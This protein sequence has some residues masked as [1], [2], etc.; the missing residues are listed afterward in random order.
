MVAAGC[1]HMWLE[2][3]P[4]RGRDHGKYCL[5]RPR[6][7]ASIPFRPQMKIWPC[8]AFSR[9]ATGRL[10]RAWRSCTYSLIG[11]A[12]GENTDASRAGGR[13]LSAGGRDL[14]ACAPK[15]TSSSLPGAPGAAARGGVRCKRPERRRACAGTDHQDAA[16]GVVRHQEG[17]AER[18][19]HLHLGADLQTAADSWMRM[20][21]S[22]R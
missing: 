13:A 3:I 9:S 15:N 7:P 5:E 21:P 19:G 2:R 11:R 20:P 4:S 16:V 1:A 22:A 10:R 6:R 12:G 18:A 8:S 14:G 17:G